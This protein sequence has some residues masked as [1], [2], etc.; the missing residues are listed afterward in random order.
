[1]K[2][3]TKTFRR[4]LK[5]SKLNESTI[6][7]ESSNY[8][9]LIDVLKEIY[10]DK[11][12]EIN[13][14]LDDYYDIQNATFEDSVDE[15]KNSGIMDEVYDDYFDDVFEIVEV[16]DS[17]MVYKE[18]LQL[19]DNHTAYNIENEEEKQIPDM[20]YFDESQILL[21]TLID[22]F[23]E[24][25]GEKL[26]IEGRSGRHICVEFSLEN[27][28]NY[29]DLRKKALEY[30]EDYIAGMN[31]FIKEYGNEETIED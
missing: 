12:E 9:F 29:S 10:E 25:T 7:K 22:Q 20:I 30:E 19:H 17:S 26:F 16:N 3:K 15:E 4:F 5:E 14:Y 13:E 21:D 24:E 18:Y 28:A 8:D 1:M 6:S 27:I 11:S 31:E 2:K 23:K